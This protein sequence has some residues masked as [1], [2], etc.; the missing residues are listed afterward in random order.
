[1][2]NREKVRRAFSPLAADPETVNAVMAAASARPQRRPVRRALRTVMVAA[3]IVLLVTGSAY[4]AVRVAS[5]NQA[6][7]VTKQ[8]LTRMQEIGL[9]PAQV[10]SGE[11]A[12]MILESNA[13]NEGEYWYGRIF[14]HCYVIDCGGSGYHLNLNVDIQT[15]K[16]TR[17]AV[18]TRGANYSD[19]VPDGMTVGRCCAMLAEY[20]G[21][22]GYTILG[23]DGTMQDKL[24]TDFAG[25]GYITVFFAGDQ[26]GVPMYIQ[27]EGFTAGEEISLL[28]GTNHLVG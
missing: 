28:I 14:P 2:N 25:A 10:D 24:L 22:G 13:Q 8:E 27:L 16:I 21:F 19:I 3:M 20:W 4:A 12:N 5:P 6:W 17:L 11:S 1:M 23:D 26:S 9:L 15:G 7:N 18:S